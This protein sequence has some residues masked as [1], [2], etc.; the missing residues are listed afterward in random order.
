MISSAKESHRAM[1]PARLMLRRD[2]TRTLRDRAMDPDGNQRKLKHLQKFLNNNK[3]QSTNKY[4]N[5]S[6]D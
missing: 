3:G 1:H 6:M 5:P 2:L 4:P